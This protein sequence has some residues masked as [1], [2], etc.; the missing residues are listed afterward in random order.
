MHIHI[1]LTT[2]V[3]MRMEEEDAFAVLLVHIYL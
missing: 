3:Q 2:N 1:F